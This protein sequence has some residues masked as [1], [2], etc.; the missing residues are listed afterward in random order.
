MNRHINSLQDYSTLSDRPHEKTAVEV[1]WVPSEDVVI[2]QIE[3]PTA[4]IRKWPELIPWLLEERLLEPVDDVHFVIL[5]RNANKTIKVLTTSKQLMRKWLKQANEA[6]IKQTS[7]VP[8]CFALPWQEGTISVAQREGNLLV[9][10]GQYSGFSAEVDQAWILI[11][12][13]ISVAP[14]PL[15][16][17][18]ATSI[19]KV[20]EKLRAQA[21]KSARQIDWSSAQVDVNINLLVNEFQQ[22]QQSKNSPKKWAMAALVLI[23]LG[24]FFAY[25]AFA[26]NKAKIELAALQQERSEVFNTLFPSLDRALNGIQKPVEQLLENKFKQREVLATSSTLLLSSLDRLLSTCDCYVESIELDGGQ[27]NL[28][29]SKTYEEDIS[30]SELS[31]FKTELQAIPD[32]DS[33]RLAIHQEANF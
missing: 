24:L 19:D 10:T 31:G 27:A 2:H 28:R 26:N 32:S 4:P 7:L 30:I 22:K 21:Q 5:G 25:T 1:L 11:E 29:L 8:D 16:I 13:L 17:I 18:F 23:S 33:Y 15:P 3:E 14:T 9:R 12:A 6:Q 20:P